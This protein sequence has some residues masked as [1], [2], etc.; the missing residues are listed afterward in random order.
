MRVLP[1]NILSNVVLSDH[2]FSPFKIRAG[3]SLD[4]T[5]DDLLIDHINWLL[6]G[7]ASSLLILVDSFDSGWN[8]PLL[9]LLKL[10]QFFPLRND[11]GPIIRLIKGRSSLALGI[12]HMFLL[13]II[14]W[15]YICSCRNRSLSWG[16]NAWNRLFIAHIPSSS[17]LLDLV[18]RGN[19]RVLFNLM[20]R[21]F[22]YLIKFLL[23]SSQ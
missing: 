6:I 11:H 14:S 5:F 2:L 4:H 10:L 7:N 8:N 9:I 13:S 1:R 16:A 18:I 15:L 22:S 21:V 17:V 19:L 12:D 20:L 23:K 3:T